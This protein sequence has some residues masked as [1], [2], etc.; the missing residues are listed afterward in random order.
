[1]PFLMTGNISIL[2]MFCPEDSGS[3]EQKFHVAN[4]FI[5][6]DLQFDGDAVAH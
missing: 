6:K 1:M 3:T 4:S 2:Q 5:R